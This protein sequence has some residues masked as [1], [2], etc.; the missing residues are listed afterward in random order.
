MV[1]VIVIYWFRLNKIYINVKM[2][3]Y[4]YLII[5]NDLNMVDL[6]K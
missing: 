1:D 2:K 3:C 5:G 6:K 4:D